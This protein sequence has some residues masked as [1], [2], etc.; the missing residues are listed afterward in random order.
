MVT[1][2]EQSVVKPG[3][4]LPHALMNESKG[5]PSPVEE[6][7]SAEALLDTNPENMERSLPAAVE[8][9][10]MKASPK[11]LTD[12]GHL[13]ELYQGD[14]RDGVPPPP[15]LSG[16]TGANPCQNFPN[17]RIMRKMQQTPRK[18]ACVGDNRSE[19][20]TG[21]RNMIEV[22]MKDPPDSVL[23]DPV[24]DTAAS[25]RTITPGQMAVIRNILQEDV[26][27]NDAS[28]AQ[29]T[30][31]GML[32]IS[33]NPASLSSRSRGRVFGQGTRR[34]RRRTVPIHR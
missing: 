20:D 2:E 7:E 10:S 16:E 14:G 18:G 1:P 22:N 5:S 29:E 3:M 8:E 9:I 11:T 26:A 31:S 19:Y 6:V 28:R 33:A 27:S 30:N 4:R 13:S 25:N 17:E 24:G 34:N 15:G 32:N 23:D 21:Y 12:S